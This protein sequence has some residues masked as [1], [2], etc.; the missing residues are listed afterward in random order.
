VRDLESGRVFEEGF[1]RLVI[2]TGGS[3]IVPPIK[4]VDL[5]YAPPFSSVCDPIL[6]AARQLIKEIGRG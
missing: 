1:D 6:I 2:A 4:G 3:P 5:S